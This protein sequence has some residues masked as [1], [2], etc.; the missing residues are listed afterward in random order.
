MQASGTWREPRRHWIEV[1]TIIVTLVLVTAAIA[2]GV[3]KYFRLTALDDYR[4]GYSVG[5]VLSEDGKGGEACR[6]AMDV[7]YR[8]DPPDAPE[9]SAGWGEFLMGCE[10]GV[11]GEPAVS[12]HGLRDRLWSSGGD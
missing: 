8:H 3:S 5:S 2:L 11:R 12:W 10:D 9:R 1:V 6:G 7:L 4:T